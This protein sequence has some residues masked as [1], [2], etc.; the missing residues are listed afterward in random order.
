VSL[1]RVH[2]VAKGGKV[3]KWHRVTRA[4]LPRDIPEDHPD[5][6]AA[7]LREEN[8]KPKRSKAAHGSI[9]MAC[10]AFLSSRRFSDLSTG[11][12]AIMRRHVDAIR[13]Q[14]G[15]ALLKDLRATHIQAD[16]INLA[17]SVA[18]ARRKAWRNVCG[19]AFD[20]GQIE[21]DPSIATKSPKMPNTGGHAPWTD[22]D[23]QR[24][25]KKWKVGTMQRAAME[26]LYW[27][28]ARVSDARR[29]VPSMNGGDGI[30]T[31]IQ[32][33]TKSPA[34][35]P[36]TSELPAWAVGM[37]ADRDTMHKALKARPVK[38][39]TYLETSQGRARS[40]KGLSNLISD[41]CKTAKIF[42]R[43]AHGLRKSRLNELAEHG[44]SATA[45]MA[46]GGHQTLKEAEHYTREA[47]RK[48]SVQAQSV[49]RGDQVYK[50]GK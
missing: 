17:P 48:R 45:I 15:A 50:I 21:V 14:G 13:E 38:G 22:D 9:D 20:L 34:H 3:Y 42:E 27:T 47:D 49:N 43:S 18:Q 25:R 8:G 41:A 29:L 12:Q 31:F 24:Y 33:K 7:W 19:L 16:L 37:A 23:I 30:L 39:L 46:W 2:R 28:G 44:G 11:Y 36:W 32:Q 10:E 4:P 6:L 40:T 5:F 35:V 1:P 26:L